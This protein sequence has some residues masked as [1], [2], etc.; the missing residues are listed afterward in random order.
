[1]ED[2]FAKAGY[3]L[4]HEDICAQIS[5]NGYHIVKDSFTY[6]ER[7]RQMFEIVNAN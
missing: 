7:L 4:E 6:P 2:A 5:S 1:M 3:Y